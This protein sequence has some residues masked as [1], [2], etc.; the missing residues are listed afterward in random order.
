M[1]K[2]W[3]IL[4]AVLI[5]GIGLLFNKQ[6]Q[7]LAEKVFYYSPCD[8]PMAYSIGTIDSRFNV[9]PDELLTDSKIAANIWSITQNKQL[10]VYDPKATDFTINMVYDSRQELTTQINQMNT[11]LKQQQDNIDPKIKAFKAQQADFEKRVNDLNSQIQYWNGKGGAPKDEY[12]KL[13]ATQTSLRNE[14]ESLN[15]TARTLGQTAQEYNLNAQKLNHT[16][17][18]YQNVLQNKPEE[19]LYEQ[20]GNKR[21]ISIYID[22]A[23]DEFLHTLSHE[24]GHAL[25][26]DHVSNQQAIMYPQTTNTLTPQDD[27]I[28]QVTNI[29]LRRPL[30][31]VVYNRIKETIEILKT[32]IK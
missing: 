26:I 22:I 12:D 30:T 5:L 19:G 10:F 29:C 18:N 27:E 6:L 1:K 4:I 23:K 28:S 11:D 20:Q 3:V 15:L 25:G 17:D 14:G 8:T 13:V 16:I 32:R 7:T 31:E 2:V 9:T 24:M 21:K